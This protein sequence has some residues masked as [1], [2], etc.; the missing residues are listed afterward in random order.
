VLLNELV[1]N[2]QSIDWDGSGTPAQWLELYNATGAAIGLANWRITTAD[3]THPAT[4]PAGQSI[5]AHAYLI[6][7]KRDTGLD[8]AQGPVRL[9]DAN[10]ATV[11]SI[12]PPPLPADQSYAR[13]PDGSANWVVDP[14]PTLNGANVVLAGGASGPDL[15]ATAFAIQT[16]IAGPLPAPP[17]FDDGSFDAADVAEARRTRTPKSQPFRTLPI[18][19]IRTLPDDSP[20]IATG[21]VTLPTG[22]WDTARAYIQASGSGILIHS[23]GATALHL[24]DSLTIKGRVHHLRGEVEIAAVKNGEQ[25][26]PGG[27]LPAPRTVQP[28]DVGG[29]TEALLIQVSGRI[30]SI[31]RDYAT[32]S[33]DSGS[34]RVYLYSRLGLSAGA[35]KPG[36]TVTLTGVVN[37]ADGSTAEDTTGRSYAQRVLTASHR[38]V[39]RLTGDIVVGGV[40]L[41]PTA[42]ASARSGSSRR[43]PSAANQPASARTGS[44]QSQPGAAALRAGAPTPFVTP[45]LSSRQ[46][47]AGPALAGTPA[48][49]VLVL[50]GVNSAALPPWVWMC[51]ALG[52]G[53][54]L[55]GAGVALAPRLRRSATAVQPAEEAGTGIGGEE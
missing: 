9:L 33:D 55:G 14:S 41:G 22:L 44:E 35:L 2:P 39:P 30:A 12:S 20:V 36:D 49:S 4:L 8:L 3:P 50:G 18:A 47:L 53:L 52:A 32:V 26:S 43:E 17:E 16:Q 6:L 42:A 27:G 38:V 28:A 40:P 7:F 51:V 29:G 1:T 10:G 31:Q 25:V 13:V 45:V 23:F 19:D 11:D 34:A 48:A 15:Q 46:P 37:A 21:V 54:I 5:G 24:G